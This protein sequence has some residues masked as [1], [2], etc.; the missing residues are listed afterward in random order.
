MGVKRSELVESIQIVADADRLTSRA[1]KR[2]FRRKHQRRVNRDSP[3]LSRGHHH[4][5]RRFCRCPNEN[6]P[7][8]MK[9]SGK[10]KT[11]PPLSANTASAMAAPI[12]SVRRTFPSSW[13]AAAR[14]E[15]ATACV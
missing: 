5:P 6:K 12:A 11:W 4:Q 2:L 1:G 14:R 7:S 8:G 15:T 3:E 10:K 13:W 9:S